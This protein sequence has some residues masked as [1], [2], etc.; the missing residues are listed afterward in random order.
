MRD[1]S[2]VYNLGMNDDTKLQFLVGTTDDG[3]TVYGDFQKTGHFISCGHVGSGHASYDEG[4]FVTYL[5]QNYSP[6]ELQFVM[7]DPKLC[8]LTPYEGIPYLWRPVIYTPENAK[9]VVSDLLQEMEHRFNILAKAGVK[10]ITEYNTTTKEKLPFIVLLGTEIADLMMVDNEFYRNAFLQLA[11]KARA[12][13]I[14]MYLATQRPGSDVLPDELLGMISGRL[15]FSVANKIDSERLLGKPGAEEITEQGRLIFANYVDN[16]VK[17]V[18]A[19]Y[20]PDTEVSKII[21]IVKSKP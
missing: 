19:P 6:A 5:L 4:F 16:E 13:G 1:V 14:H 21:E 11:M 9:V 15:I 20:T 10:N 2:L 18:K 12:V 8:Q 3:E 17:I 7:I